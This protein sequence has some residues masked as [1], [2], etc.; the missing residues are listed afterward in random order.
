MA[1]KGL[2][3]FANYCRDRNIM[4]LLRGFT[5]DELFFDVSKIRSERIRRNFER[6]LKADNPGYKCNIKYV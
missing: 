5:E 1:K 2:S 3:T 4:C 6:R